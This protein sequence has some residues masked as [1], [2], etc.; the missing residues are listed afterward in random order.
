MLQ[1]IPPVREASE[2]KRPAPASVAVPLTH[3]PDTPPE[4]GPQPA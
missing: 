3:A 4:P 1:G 2:E